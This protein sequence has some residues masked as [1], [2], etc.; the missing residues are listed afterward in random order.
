MHFDYS[1]QHFNTF[2]IAARA[3]RFLDIASVGQLAATL[4]DP[5]LAALPRLVLGG[6]SNLLFTR[7]FDGL[8]L[9]MANLGKES[10][11]MT[12]AARW[13]ALRPAKTGMVLSSGPCSRDLEAW[14]TCR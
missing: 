14:K 10:W 7:D 5:A 13:C 3:R 2:G 1:L 4:A 8:V 6:G 12:T 11:G 9:R